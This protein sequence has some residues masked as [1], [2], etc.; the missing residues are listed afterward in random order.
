MA[1]RGRKRIEGIARQPNGQPS[2][3]KAEPIDTVALDARVRMLKDKWRVGKDDA[4]EP[5]LSTFVGRLY[6]TKQ[7]SKVQYEASQSYLTLSNREQKRIA[8]GDAHYEHGETIAPIRS[9]DEIDE[10]NRTLKDRYAA[11]QRAI[12]V[13][14]NQSRG[15]LWAALQ[16]CKSTNDHDHMVGDMRLALNA[17]DLF[18]NGARSKKAA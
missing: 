9:Q 13:A 18:F 3:S 7:I 12:Q 16:Y 2:R 17:A 11:F 1:K 6:F 5:L 8:S 10:A 15:N 4:K 14:Q